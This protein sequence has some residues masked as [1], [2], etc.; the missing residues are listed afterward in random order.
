M[1]INKD[2][3]Y[4][5]KRK[6]NRKVAE[7]DE[8]LTPEQI[9]DYLHE[10]QNLIID[11][12]LKAPE[13]TAYITEFLS[14]LLVREKKLETSSGAGFVF[15]KYPDKF[16][17]RLKLKVIATKPCEKLTNEC[18]DCKDRELTVR[19]IQSDD[20]SEVSKSPYWKSSFEYEEILAMPDKGGVRLYTFGDFDISS[21]YMDYYRK[22]NRPLTPSARE[23]GTYR[24]PDGTAVEKDQCFELVSQNQGDL[25][26]DIATLLIERDT[27]NLQDWQSQL[28]NMLKIKEITIA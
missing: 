20:F 8:F 27:K 1:C 19:I 5:V 2:L 22:P 7:S 13:A 26:V 4:R 15:A 23:E 25:V 10:S 3:Q 24:L 28:T 11:G 17:R 12:L 6:V 9:D 14:D 21:V 16:L 18:E